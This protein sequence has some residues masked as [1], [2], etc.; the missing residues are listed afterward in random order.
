GSGL[1]AGQLRRRR[2]LRLEQVGRPALL[3]ESARCDPTGFV[4]P[5]GEYA[6]G[7]GDCSITGGYVYRGQQHSALTGAYFFADYCTGRFRALSRDAGGRWQLT[8]L[9]NANMAV[10]SFG[11]D[12][13]GEL[14]VLGYDKG[15]L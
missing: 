11:E 8:E 9:I 5:I 3:P 13:Q 6:H 14:Y 15:T 4:A 10:S 1:A 2:E 7:G 12:E